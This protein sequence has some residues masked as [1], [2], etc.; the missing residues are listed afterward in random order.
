MLQNYNSI[1]EYVALSRKRYAFYKEKMSRSFIRRS[2]LLLVNRVDEFPEDFQTFLLCF[3]SSRI[4][5]YH[6]FRM[7]FAI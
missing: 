5:F 1:N 4:F 6:N 2:T 3:L 7:Y